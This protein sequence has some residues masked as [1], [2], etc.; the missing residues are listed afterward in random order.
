MYRI[1]HLEQSRSHRIVW[2][3]EELQLNYELVTYKRDPQTLRAPQSLCAIHPLGKSPLLED[4]GQV[5]SESASIIDYLLDRHNH[6]LRPA[7]DTSAYEQYRYWLHFSEAS[8]M[9]LLFARLI[10]S[11]TAKPPIP[12]LLRPITSKVVNG[13][14]S[15]FFDP[16]LSK[17]TTY[18]AD[19]LDQQPYFVGESFTAADIQMAYPVSAFAGAHPTIDAW[20]ERVCSRP[21]QQRAVEK[22]AAIER[23]GAN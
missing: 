22:G 20:L 19:H 7:Y 23:P 4:N 18:L 3:A 8:L 2:L 21:A 12:A 5:I 16:E 15:A 10:V 13:I 17:L 11:R 6:N 14:N 1:H 9:P